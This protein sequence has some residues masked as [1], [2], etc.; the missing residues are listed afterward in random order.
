MYPEFKEEVQH[1]T[2]KHG[3]SLIEGKQNREKKE[4]Y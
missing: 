1:P 3:F 2:K 4:L